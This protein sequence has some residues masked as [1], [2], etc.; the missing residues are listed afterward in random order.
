MGL[1]GSDDKNRAI[2]SLKIPK[3]PDSVGD[4][5]VKNRKRFEETLK[6]IFERLIDFQF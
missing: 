6:G 4:R 2:A 1:N 5:L 3:K